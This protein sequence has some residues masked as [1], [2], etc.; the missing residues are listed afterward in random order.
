[1]Y[2]GTPLGR[3]VAKGSINEGLHP[4]VWNNPGEPHFYLSPY[5][6]SDVSVLINQLVAGDPRFL[7]LAAPADK[8][9]YNYAG[10]QAL[11][12]MIARGAR[13]AYWD[14]IRQHRDSLG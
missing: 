3:A 10:D 4:G 1:M 9:S 12:Q 7:F 6:G 2:P 14:I 8:G 11:C 13:G 5:L